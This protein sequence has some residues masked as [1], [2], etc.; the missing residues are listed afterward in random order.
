MAKVPPAVENWN[1]AI[2]DVQ[3]ENQRDTRAAK[4]IKVVSD[5]IIVD[6][7]N[8]YMLN[9]CSNFWSLVHILYHKGITRASDD[10]CFVKHL[11]VTCTQTK[12][13]RWTKI[14]LKKIT[15]FHRRSRR[16]FLHKLL[17]D[18]AE[19]KQNTRAGKAEI[20]LSANTNMHSSAKQHNGRNTRELQVKEKELF[21]IP[22]QTSPVA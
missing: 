6:T 8:G 21:P 3:I 13:N 14:K 7:S 5:E 19:E 20:N 17:H 18:V 15:V 1:L 11:H 4:P 22:H 2:S 10:R 16:K 12:T 9:V